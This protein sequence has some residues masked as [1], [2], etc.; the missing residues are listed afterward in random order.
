MG[1]VTCIETVN[2]YMKVSIFSQVKVGKK[3]LRQHLFIVV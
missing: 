3:A 2:M 1:G